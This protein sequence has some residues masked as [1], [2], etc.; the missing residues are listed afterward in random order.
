MRPR[1]EPSDIPIND[2]QLQPIQRDLREAYHIDEEADAGS[3]TPAATQV[4]LEHD[5]N[6]L[7]F[8][9]IYDRFKSR[10]KS[11]FPVL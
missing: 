5:N 9:G 2:A 4:G 11:T 8:I 3:G 6:N 10:I 1:S 7:T